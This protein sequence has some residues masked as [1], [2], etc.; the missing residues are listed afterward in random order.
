MITQNNHRPEFKVSVEICLV[1]KGSGNLQFKG[2]PLAQGLEYAC[3]LSSS[4]PNTSKHL[5]CL[6]P[7]SL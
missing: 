7:V 5:I 6:F 1:L 2:M 3:V 4:G